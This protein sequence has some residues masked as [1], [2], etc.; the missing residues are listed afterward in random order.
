[1]TNKIDF[2]VEAILPPQI[3]LVVTDAARRS[4]N[5]AHALITL[6]DQEG[7]PAVARCTA[8]CPSELKD[9]LEDWINTEIKKV[10]IEGKP[11][12]GVGGQSR[13]LAETAL[14]QFDVD[15]TLAIAGGARRTR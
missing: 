1:M 9:K 4:N 5:P 12:G 13:A 2:T 11:I 15:S 8:P 3:E 7:V 14:T 6:A 10:Q